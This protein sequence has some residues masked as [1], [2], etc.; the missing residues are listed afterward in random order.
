M[1][2]SITSIVKLA[3]QRDA[4]F[5]GEQVRGV[6]LQQALKDLGPHSRYEAGK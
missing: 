2:Y 3:G 6:R 5:P 1:F 4:R